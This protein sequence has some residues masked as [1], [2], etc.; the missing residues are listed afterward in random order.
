MGTGAA[1][2]KWAKE[3]ND[4]FFIDLAIS[5][6]GDKVVESAQMYGSAC[7]AGA[8]AAAIAAAQTL[9][10]KKGYLLGHTTSAEVAQKKFHQQSNDSVGYAAIVY[11]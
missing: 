7:G 10:A 8:V 11:G 1:A 4:R 2:L 9:Q 3:S 5:M 6:Q